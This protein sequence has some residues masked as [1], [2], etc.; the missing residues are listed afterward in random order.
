MNSIG[1]CLIQEKQRQVIERKLEERAQQERDDI[2]KQRQSLFNE[3]KN[4]QEKLKKL[5]QKMELVQI[6]S[7]LHL[8]LLNLTAS[9]MLFALHILFFKF[10]SY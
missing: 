9:L 6:V 3:R 2:R 4:Q 1:N 7:Q 8:H 5:E 10:M